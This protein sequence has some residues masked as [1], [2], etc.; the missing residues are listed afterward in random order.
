M[1]GFQL[2][3]IQRIQ[4]LRTPGIR[5]FIFNTSKGM[6]EMVRI[7]QTEIVRIAKKG[8]SSTITLIVELFPIYAIQ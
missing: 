1:N 8:N 5:T 3:R 4:G 7:A 2:I 6:M